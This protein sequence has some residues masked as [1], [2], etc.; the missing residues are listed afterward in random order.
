MK[1]F[2]ML[3]VVHLQLEFTCHSEAIRDVG[4][5]VSF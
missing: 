3:F 2:T 5:K 1:S 4:K